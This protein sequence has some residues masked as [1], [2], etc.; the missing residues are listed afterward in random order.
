MQKMKSL[1]LGLFATALVCACSSNKYTSK[2]G[3]PIF[4]TSTDL[5]VD[6]G[7]LA[8]QPEKLKTIEN[9]CISTTDWDY[10]MANVSRNSY[11][12]IEKKTYENNFEKSGKFDF[13]L[14]PMVCDGKIYDFDKKGTLKV[15]ELKTDGKLGK[16]LYKKELLNKIEKHGILL[17]NARLEDEIIYFATNNGVVGAVDW[18]NDKIIWK[19]QVKSGF[20][21]SPTIYNNLIMLTSTTD[22]VFAFNK[23]TGEQAWIIKE[24]PGTTTSMQT[25]PIAV[26]N[27]KAYAGLSNGNVLEIDNS[28]SVVGKYKVLPA[29]SSGNI[30]EINDVDFP[31]IVYNDTL[32]VGGIKT[33]IVGYNL[34]YKQPIWQ[35]PTNLNSYIV[36][37][38]NGFGY[39][40]NDLGERICFEI[41]TGRVRSVEKLGDLFITKNFAGYLNEG[42]GQ[43]MFPINRFYQ[44]EPEFE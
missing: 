20:M 21:A 13:Y 25:A 7:I 6:V 19:N 38:D 31:P 35:I 16:T 14:H 10:K 12:Q 29:K 18:K 32:V 40:V 33:S 15:F 8:R 24:Q 43:K 11:P 28:G 2:D 44:A 4:S 39:F 42:N 22:E 27:G 34:K 30:V 17:T 23:Q 41:S 1:L 5:Q 3:D 36:H 9:A 37:T 26:F